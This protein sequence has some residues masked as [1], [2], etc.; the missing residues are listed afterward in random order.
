VAGGGAAQKKG[1]ELCESP[2]DEEGAGGRVANLRNMTDI[3]KGGCE[4]VTDF[5][6]PLWHHTGLRCRDKV[7]GANLRRENQA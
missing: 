1:E 7:T 5:I 3:G 6:A 2:I 4:G